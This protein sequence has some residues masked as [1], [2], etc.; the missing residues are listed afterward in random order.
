MLKRCGFESSSISVFFFLLFNLLLCSSLFMILC[1]HG[2]I[3]FESGIKIEN[4]S[5]IRNLITLCTLGEFNTFL[6]S[7]DFFLI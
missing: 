6:S 4:N 5:I 3:F 1:T 2:Y 7:A